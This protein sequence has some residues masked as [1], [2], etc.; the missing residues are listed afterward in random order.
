MGYLITIG[1]MP[2]VHFFL[3][4][5]TYLGRAGDRRR[6]TETGA[7][8]PPHIAAALDQP[9]RPEPDSAREESQPDSAREESQP[10]GRP[11]P[12][13]AREIREAMA[14]LKRLQIPELKAR[15]LLR[16]IV[17]RDRVRTWD[18]G[19]LVREVLRELGPPG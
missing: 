19:E 12:A 11:P 3:R 5:G 9:P 14:A 18:A 17:L 1:T 4:D 8:P 2:E 16:Q 7:T 15:Q 10:A 13:K 6:A